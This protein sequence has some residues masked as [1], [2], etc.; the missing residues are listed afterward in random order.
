[1]RSLRVLV[2]GGTGFIE[3]HLIDRLMNEDYEVTVLDNFSAGKLKIY[4][5]KLRFLPFECI[6]D[7]L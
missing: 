1:M 3:S 5:I 2:T 6:F 4:N 7:N